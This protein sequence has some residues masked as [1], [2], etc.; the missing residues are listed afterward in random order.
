GAGLPDA[1]RAE[2]I[3]LQKKITDEQNRFSAN[4]GNDASTITV[5]AAQAKSL[6]A[7]FVASSLKPTADGG[8]TVPVNESSV[9]PF[10]QNETDPAARKA[11]YIAY[12]NRGGATNVALLEDAIS[13]RDRSAHLLGY[14]TWAA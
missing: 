3:S 4:L 14:K 2:F 5:T 12:G 13:L 6:P 10:L 8:F 1:K 7:D 9:G 11:F